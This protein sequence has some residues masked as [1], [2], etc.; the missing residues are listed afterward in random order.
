MY[1]VLIENKKIRLRCGYINVKVVLRKNVTARY[2]RK[3]LFIVIDDK[4]NVTPMWTH[5]KREDCKLFP[6]KCKFATSKGNF[7]SLTDGQKIHSNTNTNLNSCFS[8]LQLSM[9]DAIHEVLFA[10]HSLMYAHHMT[11]LIQSLSP[12]FI[13]GKINGYPLSTCP[14]KRQ[15]VSEHGSNVTKY[16]FKF[17]CLLNNVI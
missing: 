17:F 9:L 8:P 3:F 1:V 2:T 10:V 16:T 7:Y 4:T 13:W 5:G 15:K 14:C 12:I 6:A 11:G